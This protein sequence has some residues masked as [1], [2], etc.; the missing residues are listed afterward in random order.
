MYSLWFVSGRLYQSLPR[1]NV[2]ITLSLQTEIEL[3]YYNG[4]QST[5]QACVPISAPYTDA[6]MFSV[7]YIKFQ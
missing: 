2:F 1:K 4:K 5:H 7:V 3:L 6:V